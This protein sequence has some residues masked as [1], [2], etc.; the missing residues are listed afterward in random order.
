MKITWLIIICVCIAI[1]FFYRLNYHKRQRRLIK[2][3]KHSIK[4]KTKARL[5]KNEPRGWFI[6]E[7]GDIR[8]YEENPAP[9]FN[10]LDFDLTEGEV[11][12]PEI[13]KQNVHDSTVQKF[14]RNGFHDT[15]DAET[16]K[17]ESS[18]VG[19]I[20][21]WYDDVDINIVLN[22]IVSRNSIISNLN[23]KSELQVLATVWKHTESDD[24][25]MRDY[26]GVQIRDCIE[27]DNVVCPTGVVTRLVSS[28][29]IN[30]PELL[31]K[32]KQ[33]IDQEMMQTASTLRTE[34]ETSEEYT[35]LEEDQKREM[36]KD[37]LIEILNENYRNVLTKKEI[38]DH[39]SWID[40]I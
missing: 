32:T 15:P 28:M 23:G 24:E 38:R 7:R 30:N 13:D 11:F 21:R 34:L 25:G 10:I 37:Q 2:E 16:A 31:P 20:K 19:D 40:Y 27:D 39:I 26:L 1:Y 14:V 4:L 3:N 22:K 35:S 5:Y 33:M 9:I 18:F 8:H 6:F 29:Y 12:I 17:N 36:F